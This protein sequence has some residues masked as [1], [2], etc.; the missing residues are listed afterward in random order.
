M[1][2]TTVLAPGALVVFGF[3]AIARAA[4]AQVPSFGLGGWGSGSN[5]F[6]SNSDNSNSDSGNSNSDDGNNGDDS[7]NANDSD[8]TGDS[9]NTDSTGGV[10]TGTNGGAYTGGYDGFG[11]NYNGGDTPGFGSGSGSGIDGFNNVFRDGFTYSGLMTYR[12]AHGILAAVAFAFLFPL[13]AILMRVV[14][15]GGA[16]LSHACVQ[17]AAFALY[18]AAAG[19][20]LY[21]IATVRIPTGASLLDMATTN[22]HPIIGLVLL[23]ALFSQPVWGW[24]HHRRFK[25]LQRRTWVSHV[26]LWLGRFG[27]TLGIINGGLGLALAGTKGTPVIV[28]SVVSAVMWLLWLLSMLVGEYRRV[29]SHKNKEKTGNLDGSWAPTLRGGAGTGTGTG[30]GALGFRPATPPLRSTNYNDGDDVLAIGGAQHD[31]TCPAPA[32]LMDV[33]SPPYTPGP[34]YATHMAHLHTG[35][36]AAAGEDIMPST[37]EEVIDE[38]DDSVPVLP[39]SAD[40]MRRGQV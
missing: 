34:H 4:D 2:A 23:I 14:P 10:N 11:G 36:A 7:G 19:L 5:P 8:S 17:L 1:K 21:L 9:G 39:A 25:R 18:I 16:L 12:V 28:Y 32:L 3:A 20:G 40:E 35:P 6:D 22:A 29:K 38:S 26:H 31:P 15:G 37:K 13:G 24:L 33:P 27:I 30:L